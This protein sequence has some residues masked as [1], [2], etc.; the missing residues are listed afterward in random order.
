M[1]HPEN[2][3]IYGELFNAIVSL[4]PLDFDV[5]GIPITQKTYIVKVC[6]LL[7]IIAFFSICIFM[8]PPYSIIGSNCFI[9]IVSYLWPLGVLV[10][11]RVLLGKVFVISYIGILFQLAL[12]PLIVSHTTTN[13]RVIEYS[14]TLNEKILQIIVSKLGV[15]PLNKPVDFLIRRRPERH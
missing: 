14:V 4:L 2:L 13:K 8:L 15:S 12:G 3:V 5:S 9:K 7:L 6:Q 11:L 1:E 10:V